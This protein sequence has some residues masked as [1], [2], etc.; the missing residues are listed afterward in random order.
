M[1]GPQDAAS[2]TV[3]GHLDSRTGKPAT[4][5]TP[6]E[7]LVPDPAADHGPQVA[8][9]ALDEVERRII[10]KASTADYDEYAR[11]VMLSDAVRV[12]AEV[13]ANLPTPAADGPCHPFDEACGGP[14]GPCRN[15]GGIAPAPD[16][17]T[18]RADLRERVAHACALP[19]EPVGP[20]AWKRADRVLA[21]LPDAP[22]TLRAAVEALAIK[23]HDLAEAAA[24]H[25]WM[26]GSS[27][28][29]ASAVADDLDNVLIDR[30]ALARP[31]ETGD[32][33]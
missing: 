18:D 3:R 4:V 28:V 13:R 12:V 30:T 16:A 33:R 27:T 14:G 2:P 23:Y 20:S 15:H 19:G 31:T 22:D 32:G 7:C 29:F 10:A 8:A 5:Y 17:Q 6:S 11:A 1:T 21:V 25:G 9:S 26:P 24:K